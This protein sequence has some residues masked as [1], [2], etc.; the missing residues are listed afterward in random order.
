MKKLFYYGIAI[1]IIF[2]IFL[3]LSLIN[4]NGYDITNN[5]LSDLGNGPSGI[6]FN[7]GVIISGFLCILFGANIY[8]LV[9]N[10]GKIGGA[11]F[12]ISGVFLISVG[13]F[14]SA[15]QNIHLVMSATFFILSAISIIFIGY[16]FRSNKTL[17][18]ISVVVGLLSIIFVIFRTIPFLEHVT[19]FGM[20]L[21]IIMISSAK[22]IKTRQRK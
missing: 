9:K 15:Q 8:E 10:A 6:F 3:A 1:P 13:L 4:F 17:F 19:V 14:P 7:S 18:Y 22:S 5:Y 12:L 11:F 21:W 16:G 2:L 20:G